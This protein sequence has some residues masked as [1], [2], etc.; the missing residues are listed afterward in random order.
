MDWNAIGA[1]ATASATVTAVVVATGAWID[2]RRQQ[3][4]WLAVAAVRLVVD[5]GRVAIV[6]KSSAIVA[7]AYM[8]NRESLVTARYAMKVEATRSY[9]DM[10]GRVHPKFALAVAEF[11]SSAE[12]LDFNFQ[13][14]EQF[15]GDA[16]RIAALSR[17]A[18]LSM[19][20]AALCFEKVMS[21]ADELERLYPSVRD[22]LVPIRDLRGKPD[23]G[24]KV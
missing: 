19:S 16:T 22:A 5:L 3:K 15:V 13:Q 17:I 21:L 8:G 18:E 20:H 2:N 6:A 7:G 1:V 4:A 10:R 14:A 23:G 11:V 9:L 12:T 24:G